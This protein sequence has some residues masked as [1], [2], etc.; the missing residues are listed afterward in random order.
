MNRLLKYKNWIID[1]KI[2]EV[3]KVPLTVLDGQEFTHFKNVGNAPSKD[4]VVSSLLQDINTAARAAKVHVDVTTAVSDHPMHASFSRHPKGQALDLARIGDE[5]TPF[6]K[7]KGNKGAN[8]SKPVVNKEFVDA[9]DR[10]VAKL[11][12]LGYKLITQDPE[13]R[14][15]HQGN[16]TNSEGGSQKVIIWKYDT[17]RSGNHYNHIH[18]SNSGAERSTKELSPVQI[19]TTTTTEQPMTTQEVELEGQ[20]QFL[21]PSFKDFTKIYTTPND[22]YQ[23]I[24]ANGVWYAKGG[25]TN[26]QQKWQNFKNWTSLERN[27]KLTQILDDRF[28]G[29]RKSDEIELNRQKFCNFGDAPMKS[30]KNLFRQIGADTKTIDL[31]ENK[32]S[33]NNPGALKYNTQYEGI[34][35]NSDGFAQFKN[36]GF[37][38]KAILVFLKTQ[39]INNRLDTIRKI[40]TVMYPPIENDLEILITQVSQKSGIPADRMIKETDLM[41]LVPHI[42][43]VTSGIKTGK[44][45]IIQSIN[46]SQSTDPRA[47]K[48]SVEESENTFI[49]SPVEIE[50]SA[51]IFV[52]YPTKEESFVQDSVLST[53][54][55]LVR[56]NISIFPKNYDLEW[57]SIESDVDNFLQERNIE[58]K[59]VTLILYGESVNKSRVYE[60]FDE[61]NNLK[62]LVLINPEPTDELL[63][64]INAIK[65]ETKIFLSYNFGKVAERFGNQRLSNFLKTVK[66]YVKS[67]DQNFTNQYFE[68]AEFNGKELFEQTLSKFKSQII[69][70]ES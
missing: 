61:I 41:S 47:G 15:I 34:I 6:D 51:S 64:A 50:E 39:L 37:G 57:S 10:L 36:I 70:F 58:L 23:Y 28:S 14:K 8:A 1:R 35:G 54:Y 42:V 19:D 66:D 38:Y 56:D 17:P 31:G 26:P 62:N 32:P 49:Y 52:F 40:L 12:E 33:N 53:N 7:L 13:L 30:R 18:V 69:G 48:S 5:T 67:A 63:N 25:P 9:A 16:L 20:P 3:Q 60:S 45:K 44:D 65:N 46:Q 24:V 59:D 27:C 11:I 55:D 29:A 21:D 43:L 22:P 68:T 2:N 4:E